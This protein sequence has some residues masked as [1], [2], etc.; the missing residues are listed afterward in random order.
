MHRLMHMAASQTALIQKHEP[1]AGRALCNFGR[2]AYVLKQ[3]ARPVAPPLIFGASHAAIGLPEIPRV[4]AL[5]FAPPE[6]ARCVSLVAATQLGRVF[7]FLPPLTSR[8]TRISR[9][10]GIVSPVSVVQSLDRF[11][12]FIRRASQRVEGISPKI[13]R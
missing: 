2:S 6:N 8:A 4:S 7:S 5:L 13:V 12:A 9:A 10:A 1:G 11:G 3:R